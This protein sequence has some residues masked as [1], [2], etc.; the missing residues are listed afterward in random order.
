MS[1]NAKYY[2][3]VPGA[4]SATCEREEAPE[5]TRNLSECLGISEP[6]RPYRHPVGHP[7]PSMR[8]D[9]PC[10][11]DDSMIENPTFSEPPCA[12]VWDKVNEEVE[13]L[14]QIAMF[15]AN[16]RPS[17]NLFF[18]HIPELDK[19]FSEAELAS[20]ECADYELCQ[21]LI[22]Q[23]KI[24]ITAQ[25]IED[26]FTDIHRKMC[27][28]LHE[29]ML[30]H[31][32]VEWV[33]NQIRLM[34]KMWHTSMRNPN[35]NFGLN[36]PERN[37]EFVKTKEQNLEHSLLVGKRMLASH[38]THCFQLGTTHD[39]IGG[40][41]NNA[42]RL[43]AVNNN[44]PDTAIVMAN[45]HELTHMIQ[46]NTI[47]DVHGKKA[48]EEMVR[49]TYH[50]L[51]RPKDATREYDAEK[52]LEA[53]YV[54]CMVGVGIARAQYKGDIK[55]F[56]RHE[57]IEHFINPDVLQMVAPHEDPTT[58]PR[59]FIDYVIREYDKAHRVTGTNS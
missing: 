32:P 3:A 45:T 53:N 38:G 35:R 33:R 20:L 51:H 49:N 30:N 17:F 16:L 8:A 25:R 54:D 56:I 12:E 28:H 1:L 7:M 15:P 2:Q 27:L 41:W 11:W 48:W 31:I 55:A 18:D 43:L 58:Y 6:A 44:L 46:D 26:I 5:I 34:M 37:V 10:L 50:A 23:V 29:G 24:I 57:G 42:S 13:R 36:L 59:A 9:V 39:N 14:D 19:F 47:L 22:Y 40:G 21:E 52:E 4:L